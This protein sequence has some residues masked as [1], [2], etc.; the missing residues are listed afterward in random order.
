MK[1]HFIENQDLH[2]L[3]AIQEDS[4]I[5]LC[6]LEGLVLD[7]S[8]IRNPSGVFRR[9]RHVLS[10]ILSLLS[11]SLGDRTVRNHEIEDIAQQLDPVYF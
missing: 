3:D 1:V 7:R 5:Y 6:K 11:C 8:S 2:G 4:S 9:H 10:H